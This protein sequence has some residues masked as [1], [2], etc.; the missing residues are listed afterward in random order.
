M[1]QL[2]PKIYLSN[3]FRLKIIAV[4]LAYPYAGLP[5]LT[6][7]IVWLPYRNPE[8]DAIP[9]FRR[10]PKVNFDQAAFKM[11]IRQ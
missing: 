6:P 1:L 11:T 10:N 4:L 7:R 8:C 5:E 3:L 9:P 2:M